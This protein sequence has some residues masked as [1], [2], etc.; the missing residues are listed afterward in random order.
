MHDAFTVLRCLFAVDFD[1]LEFT[2]C[3]SHYTQFMVKLSSQEL[4]EREA[5][6]QVSYGA[7]IAKCWNVELPLGRSCRT[8]C[9]SR[10]LSQ[11]CTQEQVL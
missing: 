7:H 1:F 6:E 2:R 4:S 5:K 11:T 3:S 9:V 10:I 8:M